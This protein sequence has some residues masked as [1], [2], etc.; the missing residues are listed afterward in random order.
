[1]RFFSAAAQAVRVFDRVLGSTAD[2]DTDARAFEG[3]A[4]VD[5]LGKRSTLRSA[6]DRG[7]E[8]CLP[9]FVPYLGLFEPAAW[10]LDVN[11]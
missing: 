5:R 9:P 6:S 8:Y 3:V 4:G 7:V 2:S 11:F 1:M 10:G